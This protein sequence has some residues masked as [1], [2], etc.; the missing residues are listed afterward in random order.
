M[1]QEH[2][3]GL[4]HDVNLAAAY[5]LALFD[6]ALE[7]STDSFH[8]AGEDV[9]GIFHPVPIGDGVGPFEVHDFAG[10]EVR[11]INLSKNNRDGP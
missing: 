11:A 4:I 10:E 5:I 8:H 6:L 2:S 7:V 1:E 3:A 9:A